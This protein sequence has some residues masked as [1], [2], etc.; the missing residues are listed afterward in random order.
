MIQNLEKEYDLDL[1]EN[2]PFSKLLSRENNLWKGNLKNNWNYH[3]HGDACDFENSKN[4]QFIHVKINR[5]GKFHVIDYFYLFKFMQTT[6]SL[7][8][9][10]EIFKTESVFF[11]TMKILEEKEIVINIDQPPLITRVL[12]KKYSS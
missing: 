3:F 6:D 10:L 8:Y 2:N 11:N 9:A 1:S 12:I 7:K 5:Q 4:K